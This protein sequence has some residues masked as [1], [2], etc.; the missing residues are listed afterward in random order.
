MSLASIQYEKNYQ[1]F[2]FF[3]ILL[4]QIQ[5][6]LTFNMYHVKEERWKTRFEMVQEI[7]YDKAFAFKLV[8]FFQLR[9]YNHRAEYIV[10]RFACF[11]YNC[12][13]T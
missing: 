7:F 10:P 9:C 2:Y 6:I 1:Q 3:D 13:L 11:D 4:L 5:I 8:S 12:Y